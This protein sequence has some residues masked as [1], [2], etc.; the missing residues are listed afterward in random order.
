M[1]RA[2]MVLADLLSL[3]NVLSTDDHGLNHEETLDQQTITVY[4]TPA[5]WL[6][7]MTVIF[8]EPF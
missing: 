1:L 4:I 8:L 5:Q 6:I 2:E 3:T 7:F